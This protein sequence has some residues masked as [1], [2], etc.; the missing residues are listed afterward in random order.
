MGG[1][2]RLAAF[3]VG[4][5]QGRLVQVT[6]YSYT[7][8]QAADSLTFRNTSSDWTQNKATPKPSPW[9]LVNWARV[10]NDHLG[11]KLKKK[12]DI[13]FENSSFRST[14][15]RQKCQPNEKTLL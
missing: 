7:N 3:T 1:S 6:E 5:S 15:P 14:F 9:N 4:V 12:K 13:H 2:G 8:V 11:Q 10:R